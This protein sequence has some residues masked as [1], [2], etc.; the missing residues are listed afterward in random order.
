MDIDELIFTKVVRYFGAKKK[1]KA[2]AN[3]VRVI[4]DEIKSRLVL[5]ARAFSGQAIEIYPANNEGGYKRNSFFLPQSMILFDTKNDNL[6]F[7]YYRVVYMTIQRELNHCWQLNELQSGDLL[8]SQQAAIQHAPKVLA[9]L[10][11]KYPGVYRIF[12]LLYETLKAKM[13]LE[14]VNH[15]FFGKWMSDILVGTSTELSPEDIV[16]AALNSVDPKSVM[17]AKAVEEIKSLQVDI[18]AQ[19]D[20]VL[21]HNF[22]KVET[23]EEFNGTWRDFDGDDDLQNHHHAMEELNMHLTVRV[24]D[25]AHAVYQTEFI[26]NSKIIETTESTSKVTPIAY[27]EWNYKIRR[28]K[29]NYVKVFPGTLNANRSAFYHT[30][31]SKHHLVLMHLRK[32]MASYHNKLL[33]IKRQKEGSELDIDALTDRYVDLHSGMSPSENVFIN[34]LKKNKDLGILLLIDASLSS[35]GYTDGN[36]IIDVAK[37]VSTLFGEILDEYHVDFS[38][39]S[40]NSQTRNHISYTI[41]KD[42]KE[43]WQ[44]AK[45]HLGGIQPAGYTRIGGALRHA[46]TEFNKTDTFNKWL[47][48]LSDGKP[49]DYDTYEGQYGIHDV[50]QSLYEL[51]Q[52]KIN[53]YAIAIEAKARYYLPQMFGQNHY[54]ILST[55]DQLIHSLIKLYEK[56]RHGQ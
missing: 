53:S 49:N 14:E 23:A 40:F 29:E 38:I 26:E 16:P 21:T 28:Y 54:Q 35:D 6:I 46:A 27:P 8:A 42:F 4:L 2:E 51:N 30:T 18:K 1:A 20:Y 10:N 33:S 3:E 22:E 52:A 44:V 34:R 5:V 36:R 7:Y 11:E 56:I 37:E 45:H 39:A 9:V 12:D 25:P 17:K 47:I 31:L 41:L 32:M 19:E 15:L 50:K 13:D 24:D 43:S 55:P 48:L